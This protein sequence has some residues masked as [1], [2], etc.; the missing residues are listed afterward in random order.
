MVAVGGDL[1]KCDL[2]PRTQD[3]SGRSDEGGGEA[4]SSGPGLRCTRARRRSAQG[5]SPGY[6]E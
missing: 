4:G 3:A 2:T 1:A 6:P 5:G